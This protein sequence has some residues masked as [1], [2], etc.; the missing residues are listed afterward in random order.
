MT[1]LDWIE[2]LDKGHTPID[3]E[4]YMK[5]FYQNSDGTQYYYNHDM[6]GIEGF[7]LMIHGP[8][9][10]PIQGPITDPGF[11]PGW[12]TLPLIPDDDDIPF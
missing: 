2:L 4:H 7:S 5:T 6:D 1:E 11:N 3:Q 10:P 9:I 12:N 8:S